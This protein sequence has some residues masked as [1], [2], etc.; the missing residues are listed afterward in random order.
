[1]ARCASTE[2]YIH[3]YASAHA[4]LFEGSGGLAEYGLKAETSPIGMRQHPKSLMHG[5][6]SHMQTAASFWA[7]EASVAIYQMDSAL[8]F[9]TYDAAI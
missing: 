1:M 9:N 3:R 5:S 8:I 2:T 4:T 6:A 7:S